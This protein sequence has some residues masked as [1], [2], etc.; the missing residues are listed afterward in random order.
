MSI[1][2]GALLPLS[3]LLLLTACRRDMQDQP[4]YKPLAE[5]NFFADHRSERPQVE[6]TIARGH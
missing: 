3:A 2:R 4:K 1:S 5:S 6:G